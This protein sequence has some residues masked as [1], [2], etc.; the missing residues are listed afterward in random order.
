MANS[1]GSYGFGLAAGLV[2]SGV[3]FCIGSMVVFSIVQRARRG[4]REGWSTR[5]VIVASVDVAAGTPV[6]FEII[7]QRSIPEQF[8]DESMITP[9]KAASIVSSTVSRPLRAGDPIRWR[10]L[11]PTADEEIVFFAARDI[12]PG[13]LN[14]DDLTTRSVPTRVLT[15]SWVRA[16]ESVLTR[17]VTTG[18]KAG[19]PILATQ[20]QGE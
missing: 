3:V 12:A 19:D 11:T 20:L 6:V 2:A 8:A 5:P 9:D 15:P 4:A 10:D 18:F 13:P 16:S 14:E 7:S 1:R 17:V